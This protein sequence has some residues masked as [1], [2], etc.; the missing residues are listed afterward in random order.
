MRRLRRSPS[1]SRRR[2][3]R[4][5]NPAVDPD[6]RERTAGPSPAIPESASVAVARQRAPAGWSSHSGRRASRVTGIGSV[7]AEGGGPGRRRSHPRSRH[8]DRVDVARPLGE[9]GDREGVVVDPAAQVGLGVGAA[10][11][12]SAGLAVGSRVDRDRVAADP[13]DAAASPAAADAHRI[14]DRVAARSTGGRRRARPAPGRALSKQQLRGGRGRLAAP[15]ASSSQTSAVY[16]PGTSGTT[17]VHPVRSTRGSAYRR[18]RSRRF[19]CGPGS[20]RRRPARQRGRLGTGDVPVQMEAAARVPG[21]F[22]AGD[23]RGWWGER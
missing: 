2:R 10:V 15:K 9:F 12:R 7:D 16:A 8:G 17:Q 6:R 19:G 11:G 14:G 20:G 1:C 21:F 22:A 5:R 18:P 23:R 3:S 13:R 4:R